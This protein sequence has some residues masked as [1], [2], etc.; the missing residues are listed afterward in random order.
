MFASD[1]ASLRWNQA[2][3]AKAIVMTKPTETAPSAS[4]CRFVADV[5]LSITY[6]VCIA[7]GFGSLVGP[8]V[9]HTSAAARSFFWSKKLSS[10]FAASHSTARSSRRVCCLT[11]SRS[12]SIAA[13]SFSNDSSKPSASI[14]ETQLSLPIASETRTAR[15]STGRQTIGMIRLLCATA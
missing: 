11:H 14:K 1:T 6:W 7:V 15:V 10:R 13:T 9:S 2:K 12:V 8:R 3:I 4:R 5:R